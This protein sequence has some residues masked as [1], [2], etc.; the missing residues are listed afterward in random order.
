M[1]KR[2]ESGLIETH[3]DTDNFLYVDLWEN[4]S[5]FSDSKLAFSLHASLP[6]LTIG[7]A[8]LGSSIKLSWDQG[9]PSW[10]INVSSIS[11]PSEK[12]GG[13]A[14]NLACWGHPCQFAISIFWPP[15][16]LGVRGSAFSN[17]WMLPALLLLYL[18]WKWRTKTH[19]KTPT[20]FL[21]RY[22]YP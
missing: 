1:D 16:Y 12:I 13:W 15:S 19:T 14:S 21:S 18:Y 11:R 5:D 9:R 7:T 17:P 4:P 8:R 10:K 22:A 2:E 6:F 3:F 20:T